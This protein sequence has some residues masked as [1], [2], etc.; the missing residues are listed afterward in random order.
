MLKLGRLTDYATLVMTQLAL[1]PEQ[2]LNARDLADRSH[3]ASPTV[4]KLLRQLSQAALVQA[5]RGAHGGYRL[6]RPAAQISI[7]AIVTA[8]EGPVA[9][10]ECAGSHSHCAIEGS[11]GVRSSWRLI[12]AAVQRALEA[13]SLQQM[14]DS[15]RPVAQ[16]AAA[17]QPLA[18]LA[19]VDSVH[20]L[21]PTHV[22]GS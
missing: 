16:R 7:A 2:M 5:E 18:A 6:A 4:A 14:A 11:C 17:V 19:P 8:I 22:S 3:V 20:R 12:N 13:V 10:T 1:A 21:F 9:L 15:A